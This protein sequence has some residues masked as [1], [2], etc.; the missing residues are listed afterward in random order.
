[1]HPKNASFKMMKSLW[2]TAFLYSYG[3]IKLYKFIC[4]NTS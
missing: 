4:I 2:Y 1:L 3:V